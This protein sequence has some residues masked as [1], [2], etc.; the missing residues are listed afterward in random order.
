MKSYRAIALK[1][2]ELDCGVERLMALANLA[3]R[4]YRV[5]PPDLP[6]TVSIM[7]YRRRHELAF[8]TEPK[9]WL[10]RTWFPLTTLRIGNGQKI[11]DGGAP[12]VLDFDRGVVK[13][14]F[15][16]HAEVPMPK[17]AYDRVSEGGDVKFALLGLKRGKPHLALV[18][19]REVELIQTNSV[20]VVDVNSWRHGVVWALIR[21]GKTTKWARVRPDLGYIERL[22]SEVVRLEHK[23]GKLER[24]GLHEGRD[25]KKLWR[26]IKQKRRRLYAYLRDFA[27]KAA[28]RLALKA[29]KRRAEVWI[30]DMLEESRRELIEEKLPSDLVKLYMLYLRRFINLLTNQLAWYGIPYRFKRLPSTVCPVCGSELTQL[31]DRT[32]VCQCGFREKRDLVPIR[33]ALKYTSP[34]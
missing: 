11:G 32:M 28:H 25:S 31:P 7:L 21:D 23:Y 17:W 27:Q 5:E 12:V 13:L 19:E 15:I 29:V 30:D 9:R 2:P 33:W 16:C 8:G 6:K 4:G 22:Y 14:R 24:L 18:A 10:A 3:H 1:L 26:Q 34:P 20:L